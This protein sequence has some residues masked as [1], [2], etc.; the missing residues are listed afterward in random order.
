MTATC[1]F[2]RFDGDEQSGGEHILFNENGGGIALFSST[3]VV[4]SNPNFLLNS[5]FYEQVFQRDENGD[6]LRMGDV[7]KRTKNATL[8]GV[9]K[10][11]FTL[12]GDPALRLSI[13]QYNVV[14]TRN[15]FV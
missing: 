12:L 6:Y 13:P 5:N 2:S 4:Y 14:T 1:E 9:N 8:S 15:N 11:N 10:R 3:R 7:M